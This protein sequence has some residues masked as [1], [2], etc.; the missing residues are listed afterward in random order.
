MGLL[1]PEISMM[2][3]K[4]VATEKLRKRIPKKSSNCSAHRILSDPER[5]MP[6]QYKGTG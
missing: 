2:A 6:L 1:R 4:K 3:G 5:A